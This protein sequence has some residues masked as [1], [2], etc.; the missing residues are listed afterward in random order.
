MPKTWVVV[1]ESSRA[2]IFELDKRNLPLKELE[3][4]AHTPSRAHEQQ[5]TSDLPGRSQDSHGHGSH[6]M[7]SQVS[8]KQHESQEFAKTI[9]QHLDSARCEGKFDKLIIMSSPAFLGQLRKQLS[10]ETRKFVHSEIDKNL[11][12]HKPT[13]IQQHLPFYI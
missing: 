1:A 11:V 10:A 9:G 5:L 4:F 12:R 8:A 3:G 13:D 6:K 7:G 2:K